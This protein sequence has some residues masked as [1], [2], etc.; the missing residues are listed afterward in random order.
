MRSNKKHSSKELEKYIQLRLEG[1]PIK[2]LKH[3][4]GL[5]ISETVFQRYLRKY[6]TYGLEGLQSRTRNNWYSKTFKEGVVEEYINTDI[7]IDALTLKYKIPSSPTVRN[8]IKKY[9]KGEILSNYYP[10]PEVYSMKKQKKTH[11]EKIEIVKDYLATGMSYK[12]T[13]KKYHISYNNV[14][15]W[16]QKYKK[17]G[18]DGLIDSRG[19]RKPSQIQTQEEQLATEITALKARNEFLETE[20][21]ALKKLAEIERELM[22]PEQN[23]KRNSER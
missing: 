23:I 1:V 16:V 7:S 9:T 20:N 17:H 15:S 22:L 10:K 11:D 12:E 6:Q 8:W 4:Y 13:A 14:Y 2:E 18:P 19:R 21:A 3:S 5:R